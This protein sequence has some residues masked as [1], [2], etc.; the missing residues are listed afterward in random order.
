MGSEMCIRDRLGV[1]GDDVAASA[2]SII[3][4]AGTS[5]M[6]QSDAMGYLAHRAWNLF[7]FVG[8]AL[9]VEKF[10]KEQSER[11][12]RTDEMISRI[13]ARKSGDKEKD[14]AFFLDL[15][16]EDRL[17]YAEEA[18][19]LGLIDGVVDEGDSSS[20]DG[21]QTSSNSWKE[22]EAA[23]SLFLYQAASGA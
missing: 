6:A 14:A 11:M 12:Q 17:I 15:M 21:D 5:V 22:A 1:F 19:E 18:Q 2:A 23:K 8:N 20:D 10:G 16:S 7:I 3:A 4:C 13:Y 9:D